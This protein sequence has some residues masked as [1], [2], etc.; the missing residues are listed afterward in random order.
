MEPGINLRGLRFEG[1]RV[2]SE[3]LASEGFIAS[4]LLETWEVLV[5]FLECAFVGREQEVLDPDLTESVSS[6]TLG[7]GP[8]MP[9]QDAA[10]GE[11]AV[12]KGK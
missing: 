1:W 3:G 11:E 2:G 10:S 12:L 7:E 5:M 8:V 6:G 9:K 4:G